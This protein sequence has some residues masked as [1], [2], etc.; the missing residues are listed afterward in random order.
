MKMKLII[1]FSLFLS[2]CINPNPS[3]AQ[4]KKKSK[5]TKNQ[6]ERTLSFSEFLSTYDE[7]KVEKRFLDVETV[8]TKTDVPPIWKHVYHPNRF[9]LLNKKL[10]VFIGTV[11]KVKGSE[12][13]G[14]WHVNLIPDQKY[15]FMLDDGN[16]ERQH[17]CFVVEM[18]CTHSSIKQKDYQ[19]EACSGYNNPF[20]KPKKGQH[21]KVIGYFVHDNSGGH[22]WNE[23]HP[24]TEFEI[25]K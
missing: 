25:T 21:V 12:A 3:E 9:T 14:D 1:L 20:D 8:D 15:A 7:A 4:S 16:Y 19:K 5:K 13:D 10:V 22:G 23:L 11:D 24:V 6:T 17:G 18:I 2:L